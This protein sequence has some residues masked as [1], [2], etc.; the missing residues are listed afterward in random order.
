MPSNEFYDC[1]I[2]G[3]ALVSAG[4]LVFAAMYLGSINTSIQKGYK[5]FS[6]LTKS[7]DNLRQDLSDLTKS[8]DNLR[9]DLREIHGLEDKAVE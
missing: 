8:L 4:A 3:S 2:M 7:L 5:K 1:V 6:D 9:H